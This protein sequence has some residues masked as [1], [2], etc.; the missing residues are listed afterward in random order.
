MNQKEEEYNIGLST[1]NDAK[2]VAEEGFVKAE[3]NIK[4]SEE[5]LNE[6]KKQKDSLEQALS[7]EELSQ[8]EK[9]RITQEINSINFLVQQ[10]IDKLSEGKA[11]LEE[12]KRN[13]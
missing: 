9:E 2:K 12:K 10:G 3:E 7:N 8:E 5:K 1:F 4:E 6:L 13:W 11:Q